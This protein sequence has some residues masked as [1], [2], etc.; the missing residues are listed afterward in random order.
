M[1]TVL[2]RD[3]AWYLARLAPPTGRPRIVIDTDAANEIDDQ[4]AL[5]WALLAPER[6]QLEAIY[7]AP[8]SFEHRRGELVRAQRA[9]DEPTHAD[10][11]DREL[12]DQHA[13]QLAYFDRRGWSPAR[14]RLPVFDPPAVGMER[15]YAEIGV[16]MDKL[17]IAHQGRVFRGSPGYLRSLAQPITSPAT[18][19][20]IAAARAGDADGD[21]LYVLAIGCVTN[22]TSAL[23]LAPDIA[24]RIVVVWTAGFPSYA[25]H[26]NFALNLEQD[27]LA[28]QWL[29]ASGVPLVYLPGYHVGAQLRLSLPD[30]ERYVRGQGAI[31]DYLHHLFTHNPLWEFLG[32]DSFYAHS[33][34]IWDVINIAWMLEPAWVPSRIVATP[35]LGD[36]RRWYVREG[37]PPMR[38]AYGVARDAIFRDFFERLARAA[39]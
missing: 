36:D 4:F 27:L 39:A 13:A 15:S 1:S 32:I 8:Y 16:V 19:H 3:A 28:S 35:G 38:E 26:T 18:E 7:A 5:T 22:I 23:L 20:L 29:F 31:G 33:W 25:P 9:R 30:M 2:H 14:L 12:L 11:V 6:L 24:E 37:A 21:P 10:A 34:V 17:G